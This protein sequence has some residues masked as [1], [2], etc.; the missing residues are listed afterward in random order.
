[1]TIRYRHYK[2]LNNYRDSIEYAEYAK[3]I[4]YSSFA[5]KDTKRS[6]IGD[7]WEITE[8]IYDDFLNMLPP[9]NYKDNSFYMREYCFDNITTRFSKSGDK[10]FC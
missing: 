7:K 5:F 3:D 9:L 8:E 2:N 6:I 10:Y 1:M 4:G